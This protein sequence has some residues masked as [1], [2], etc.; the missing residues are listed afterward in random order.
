MQTSNRCLQS[1][2]LC[3]LFIQYVFVESILIS[4]L[5]MTQTTYMLHGQPKHSMWMPMLHLYVIVN[6]SITT[7]INMLLLSF[8]FIPWCW[9]GLRIGLQASQVPPHQTGKTISL[10]TWP[11]NCCHKVG[12]TLSDLLSLVG[13]V[14]QTMKN[15]PHTL[16][17]I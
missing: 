1:R 9:I 16:V 2:L 13:N 12:S 14:T 10:R 4:F 6:I 11:L 17:D 15:I 5:L 8:Q 7:F 3:P